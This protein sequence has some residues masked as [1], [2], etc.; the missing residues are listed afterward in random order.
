MPFGDLIFMKMFTGKSVQ[1]KVGIPN[2]FINW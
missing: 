1:N 2:V